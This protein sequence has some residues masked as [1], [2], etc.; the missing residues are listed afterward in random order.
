[1]TKIAPD[2][3][4]FQSKQM[5]P[6]DILV[7]VNGTLLEGLALDQVW[8]FI[9]GRPNTRVDLQLLRPNQQ[10][11][12]DGEAEDVYVSIFRG[13]VA[14]PNV[15]KTAFSQLSSPD[16]RDISFPHSLET[17]KVEEPLYSQVSAKL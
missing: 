6:G 13:L 11:E 5:F 9:M 4:A 10:H 14:S 16:Q 15:Y 12:A 2:G 1:M 7:Q 17:T 3:P 8:S